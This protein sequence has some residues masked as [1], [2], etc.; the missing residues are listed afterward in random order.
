M[1]AYKDLDK[2]RATSRRFYA[3]HADEVKAARKATYETVKW[4]NHLKAKYGMTVEQYQAMLEAQGGVCAITGLPPDDGE[5]LQV[6]HCHAANKVRGLIRKEINKALGAFQ[7]NPEWL[8]KAADYVRRNHDGRAD[9]R[10][11][12]ADHRAEDS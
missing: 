9:T 8:V 5:K 1:G 7:D 2:R 10:D 4:P 12:Q 3:R 11:G 6:D